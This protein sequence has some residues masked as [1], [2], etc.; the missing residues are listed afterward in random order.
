MTLYDSK[1]NGIYIIDQVNVEESITRRLEA[2]G[3]NEGTSVKVLNRKK[4]GAMV[5]QVRGTRL[6]LGKSIVSQIIVKEAN[7]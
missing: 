5:I 1:V 3:I 4:R 7:Q 6:A 2:L